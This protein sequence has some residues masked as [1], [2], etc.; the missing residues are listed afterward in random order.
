MSPVRKPAPLAWTKTKPKAGP[1]RGAKALA[2]PR[3]SRQR[4]P[5]AMAA[6]DWPRVLRRQFGSE[7]PFDL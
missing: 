1:Q 5:A 6:D 7:Q 2:E 3:L 4:R